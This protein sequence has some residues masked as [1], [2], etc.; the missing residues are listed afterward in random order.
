VEAAGKLAVLD[1]LLAMLRARGHRVVLFSQFNVMLDILEDYLIMRGYKCE[2]LTG[3]TMLRHPMFSGD[4]DHCF[5]PIIL[6][7]CS[8]ETP[9]W[10]GVLLHVGYK[11]FKAG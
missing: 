7:F 1:R 2:P 5:G 11:G 9:F 8:L 4:G 3:P 10:Q 6:C